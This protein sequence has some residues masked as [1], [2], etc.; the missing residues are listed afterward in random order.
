VLEKHDHGDA[1][2]SLIE[3]LVVMVIVGIMSTIAIVGLTRWS[4]ASD[5][6]GTAQGLET[7]LRQTQ[8]RAVTEGLTFCV[9]IDAAQATQYRGNCSTGTQTR[10]YKALGDATFSSPVFSQ[11]D[12]TT[13]NRVLFYPRGTASPGQV[14]VIRPESSVL[15]V[16]TVEGLTG[17]VA[18]S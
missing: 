12:G 3:V 8:M 6:K 14:S 4:N 2:I 17:R 5:H 10:V 11:G 1:G 7:V 15:R 18:A 13:A 16:V 9:R